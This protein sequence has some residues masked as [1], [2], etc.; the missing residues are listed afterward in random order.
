M[1]KQLLIFIILTSAC[2]VYPAKAGHTQGAGTP[3]QLVHDFYVWYF[4]VYDAIGLPA[5]NG[6]MYKYVAKETVDYAK[7]YDEEIDYFTQSGGFHSPWKNLQ[8]IVGNPIAMEN[9]TFVVPV[10]FDFSWG[11]WHIVVFVK[12]EN[13]ALYIVKVTDIFPYS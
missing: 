1:L 13:N 5:R 2:I 4:K 10:T 8:I 6:E 3:E 11:N 12:E 9:K 7:T